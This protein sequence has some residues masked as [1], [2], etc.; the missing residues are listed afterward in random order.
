MPIDTLYSKADQ[1]ISIPASGTISDSIS[2]VLQTLLAIQ[3]PP[4]WTTADLTFR[5]SVDGINF[6]NMYDQ[7]GNEIVIKAGASRF[8][9]VNPADWVGV[10]Y[11][12]VRSGTSGTPVAQTASRALI[13]IN[14][15]VQ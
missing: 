8:I 7:F 9:V 2:L 11:L 10:R 1:Y 13:L 14:R 3:T 12:V 5:A 4:E 6:D 15:S